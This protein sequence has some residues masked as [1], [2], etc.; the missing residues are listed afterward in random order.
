M[1]LTKSDVG[2]EFGRQ[3]GE[4]VLMIS[5]HKY[6]SVFRRYNGEIQLNLNDGRNE[7]YLTHSIRFRVESV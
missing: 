7:H 6:Q 4:I 3:D 5:H 2:K 1:E